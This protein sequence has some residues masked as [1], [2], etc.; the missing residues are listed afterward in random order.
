MGDNSKHG[1]ANAGS[2]Y[3]VNASIAGILVAYESSDSTADA[4]IWGHYA[5]GLG[6]GAKAIIE[7]FNDGT[8]TAGMGM[9]RMDF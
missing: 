6:G 4:N 5:I 2:G 9:L 3:G 1:V 8:N 7:L